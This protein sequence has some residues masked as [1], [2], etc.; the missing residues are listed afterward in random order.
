[1]NSDSLMNVS[2]TSLQTSQRK[3]KVR[4]AIIADVGDEDNNDDYASK[5]KKAKSSSSKAKDVVETFEGNKDHL[6]T[7]KEIEDLRKEYGDSWL[8]SHG[9]T[10]VQNVMGIQSSLPK[11]EGLSCFKS[12]P[13]T[14]EQLI[15]NL[16]GENIGKVSENLTSTPVSSKSRAN[17]TIQSASDVIL[18]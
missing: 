3:V 6:K 15:E 17:T 18:F 9:A 7:K 8:Q 4:R 1:M 16:F 11:V 12:P 14:T 2:Q 5:E 13:Q 10:K